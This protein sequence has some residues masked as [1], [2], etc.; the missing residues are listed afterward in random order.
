MLTFL[1]K[2]GTILANAAGIYAGIG[3]I[4]APYLGSEGNK[5]A[6]IAVNDLLSIGQVI[7][8]IE[9]VLGAGQGQA[10]LKAAVPLVVQILKTSQVVSGKKIAD[11]VL[12]EKAATEITQGVVD[13]LNS[14][15]PD[16][17]QHA[18]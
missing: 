9:A 15:S 18:S 1:K 14:I 6:G 10:K 11:A 8:Q 5:Y 16:A 12:F 13:L 17:A 2:L 4:I 7:V 3:P